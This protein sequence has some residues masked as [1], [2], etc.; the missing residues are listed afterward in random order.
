MTS[1]R[2]GV[3]LGLMK[4]LLGILVSAL[5]W[6]NFV[7]AGWFSKELYINC[8]YTEGQSGYTMIDVKGKDICISDEKGNDRDCGK[9]AEFNSDV[10]KSQPFYSV[11]KPSEQSFQKVYLKINRKSSIAGFYTVSGN[12]LIGKKLTCKKRPSL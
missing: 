11:K 1:L 3:K 6:S 4:K 12:K 7:Y 5:L 9:V 2:S 10:V 8:Y